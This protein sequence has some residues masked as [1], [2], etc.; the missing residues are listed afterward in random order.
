MMQSFVVP[1]YSFYVCL[2]DVSVFYAFITFA[3]I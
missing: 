3:F 2:T 1:L